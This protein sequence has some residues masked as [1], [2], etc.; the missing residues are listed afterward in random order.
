MQKIKQLFNQFILN[1]TGEFVISLFLINCV[2]L[3]I[4]NV[5]RAVFHFRMNSFIFLFF[6]LKKNPTFFC[7]LT[8]ILFSESLFKYKNLI[9]FGALLSK[10][11]PYFFGLYLVFSISTLH[12]MRTFPE[13]FYFHF[14]YCLSVIFRN[15]FLVPILGYSFI[16]NINKKK[17]ELI[18]SNQPENLQIQPIQLFK[19][20]ALVSDL[21]FCDNFQKWSDWVLS[22]KSSPESLKKVS[23]ISFIT[24]VS[25]FGFF[26]LKFK[27]LELRSHSD[28]VR[29]MITKNKKEL[30]TII[31]TIQ[32]DKQKNEEFIYIFQKIALKM[33][34][35]MI[36]MNSKIDPYLEMGSTQFSLN[37]FF[38][39]SFHTNLIKELFSL[40]VDVHTL[41]YLTQIKLTAKQDFEELLALTRKYEPESFNDIL[42]KL[43]TNFPEIFLNVDTSIS[44]PLE[45]T[46]FYKKLIILFFN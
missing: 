26:F 42:N 10:N 14:F 4:I 39:Q 5:L 9:S 3:P 36:Q 27:F 28:S 13:S 12:L 17:F 35:K 34:D 2:T 30:E 25:W 11:S 16:V 29:L 7:N 24:S 37:F 43:A 40:K 38:Y 23:R 31:S 8:R 15:V 41:S 20:T 21:I 46:N 33:N 6:S 45:L 1:L 44:S 32:A 18:S 22:L 19:D